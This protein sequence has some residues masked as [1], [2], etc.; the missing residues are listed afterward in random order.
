M[1]ENI[2]GINVKFN[3]GAVRPKIHALKTKARCIICNNKIKE[4]IDL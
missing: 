1:E 4:L 3:L 2:V